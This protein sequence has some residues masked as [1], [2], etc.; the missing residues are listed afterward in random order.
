MWRHKR[1]AL[2]PGL[3]LNGYSRIEVLAGIENGKEV[4]YV[5]F[6]NPIRIREIVNPDRIGVELIKG[7]SYYSSR[8]D[9]ENFYYKENS[10]L[11]QE[12]LSCLGNAQS[13]VL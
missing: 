3:N 13:G 10:P 9:M 7:E 1:L 12:F 2:N 6:D 11:M 4:L 5:N 8:G